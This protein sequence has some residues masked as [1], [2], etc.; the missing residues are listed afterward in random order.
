MLPDTTTIQSLRF[1][2]R[3]FTPAKAKQWARSHGFRRTAIDETPK[4]YRIRQVDPERFQPRSFRT[5]ELRPG[6]W[7]VIGRPMKHG[8]PGKGETMAAKKKKATKKAAKAK[9][10]PKRKAA[11]K[12]N[13]TPTTKMQIELKWM[14]ADIPGPRAR[15]RKLY[16][17]YLRRGSERMYLGHVTAFTQEEARRKARAFVTRKLGK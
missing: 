13:G 7:A 9:A 11:P 15:A 10:A 5:I 12:H 1:C 3:L 2:R 8:N 16:H 6:V 4:Q 17:A 14:G